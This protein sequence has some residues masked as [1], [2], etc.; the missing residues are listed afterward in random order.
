MGSVV[1]P[2]TC[3]SRTW[4][5]LRMAGY[6]TSPILFTADMCG[7]RIHELAACSWRR[8]QEHSLAQAAT[9]P[10][11]G[12]SERLPKKFYQPQL[13]LPTIRVGQP[14]GRR[15]LRFRDKGYDC[16]KTLG[17]SRADAAHALFIRR[18]HLRGLSNLPH[19]LLTD[20]IR[21]KSYGKLSGGSCF[22]KCPSRCSIA[23]LGSPG[24]SPTGAKG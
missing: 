7:L 17:L 10:K 23:F 2:G 9:L 3:G 18:P 21:S 4:R 19:L 24:P 12:L 14:Y 5:S 1:H 13:G 16:L 6:T 15:T 20:S 11:G 8:L 22:T